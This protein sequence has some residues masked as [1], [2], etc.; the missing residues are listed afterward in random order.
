MSRNN[1]RIQ[2]ECGLLKRRQ[3]LATFGWGRYDFII[4]RSGREL[5]T[6]HFWTQG[7]L[8]CYFKLGEIQHTSIDTPLLVLLNRRVL[9]LQ[10]RGPS[11]WMASVVDTSSYLVLV[12]LMVSHVNPNRRRLGTLR[13]LP[14]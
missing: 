13:L 10:L 11:I 5:G 9:I 1:C 12:L 8:K 4:N 14:L 2:K 6:P 7:Y 3:K